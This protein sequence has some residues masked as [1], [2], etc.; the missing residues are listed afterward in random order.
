MQ[1]YDCEV[2][3]A[4]MRYTNKHQGSNR[5]VPFTVSSCPSQT[6]TQPE[7]HG[8]YRLYSRFFTFSICWPK[9]MNNYSFQ[10]CFSPLTTNLILSN[11]PADTSYLLISLPC[12]YTG[13]RA[14][15]CIL[16][17]RVG[18]SLLSF[19]S[20]KPLL[21]NNSITFH[22]CFVTKTGNHLLTGSSSYSTS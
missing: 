11:Q 7:Q 21:E 10:P 14:H 8:V 6:S 1:S 13:A 12:D 17:D 4:S 15:H 18:Y 16:Y 19:Q 3:P 20:I 5:N 2:G 9:V 22:K